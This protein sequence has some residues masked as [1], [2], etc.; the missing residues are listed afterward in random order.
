MFEDEDL[1]GFSFEEEIMEPA[2]YTKGVYDLLVTLLDHHA[3][4]LND[5][6][7]KMLDAMRDK[8]YLMR[9]RD[10][11]ETEVFALLDAARD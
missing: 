9:D 4:G 10:A 5:E 6:L 1:D 11:S 2:T 7:Y 3:T 8:V